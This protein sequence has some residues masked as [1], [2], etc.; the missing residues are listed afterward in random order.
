MPAPGLTQGAAQDAAQDAAPGA[1]QQAAPHTVR[2]AIPADA[3]AVQTIFERALLDADWLPPGAQPDTDFQRNAQGEAVYVA[4]APDGRIS[5]VIAVYVAGAFI[6]HCY[7]AASA[8]RQGVG[9][10]LLQS[11]DGWLPRPWRLKC[12][13]VNARARAFYA[14]QGWTETERAMGSQGEYVVLR[15][16]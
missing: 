4:V 16:F 7:V 5:G 13:V 8:Q 15:R 3:A 1:A 6:H 10:A 11:L 14:S 12:V 2:P 9:R